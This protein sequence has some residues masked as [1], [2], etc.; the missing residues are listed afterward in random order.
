MHISWDILY[1]A[2]IHFNHVNK[3]NVIGGGGGL[4]PMPD[5]IPFKLT[6]DT[7]DEI[8]NQVGLQIFFVTLHQ[9]TISVAM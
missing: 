6:E 1:V 7:I 9:A 2:Y 5:G 4:R 8:D 3:D